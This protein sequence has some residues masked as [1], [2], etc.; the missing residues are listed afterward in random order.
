MTIVLRNGLIKLRVP[1]RLNQIFILKTF[2]NNIDNIKLNALFS[3]TSPGLE[4]FGITYLIYTHQL[5][6][7]NCLKKEQLG[8]R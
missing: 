7:A 5:D 6:L 1:N 2:V 4:G 8:L 3:T